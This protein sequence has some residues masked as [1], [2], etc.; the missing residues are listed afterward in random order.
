MTRPVQITF[1]KLQQQLFYNYVISVY[2]N[3]CSNIFYN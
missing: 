2:I 1:C 3:M